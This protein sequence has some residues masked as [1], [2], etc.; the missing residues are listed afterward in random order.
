MA[1]QGVPA[2]TTFVWEQAERR[3]EAQIRQAEGLD[4]KAGALVALHA[5]AAGLIATTAGHFHGGAKWV[6]VGIVAE[7]L[8]SGGLGLLAFGIER[9]RRQPSPETM[10]RFADWTSDQIQQRFLS[11]RFRALE[12]NRLRLRRKSRLLEASLVL[13]TVVALEAAAA[14]IVGLV[15]RG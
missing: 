5:L 6:L 8:V 10:W 12:V 15:V 1:T 13:V 2:G 9:Y 11:S 4:T 3:L 14:A 7:L